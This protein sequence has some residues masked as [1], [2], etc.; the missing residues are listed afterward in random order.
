MAPSWVGDVVMATPAIRALR[1]RFPGARITVLTRQT[2]ADVL[3]HNPHI[4]RTIVADKKGVGP[5]TDNTGELA[6]LLRAG[7]FDLAVLLPNSF[8][9]ALLAWRAQAER[10]VGYAVQWRSMLLTDR[11]SP[12]REDGKIV[13]INMVDRYLALC[14][15][16]GCTE[17]SQDEE[18]FASEQDIAG[19]NEVLA[20]Q[21]I[22]EDDPLAVLIPGASYG[23]SKLWGAEKFAQVADGLVDRHHFK[24]LAHVGPGEEE[25]GQQVADASVRGVTV[26]PP[27]TVDLKLLKGVIR[28]SAVVIANDTGPRHYAVAYGVPNVAVLGPT[29]RRYIDVN[30]EH[31]ELVQAEVD[32]GPCQLKV[33]P[34]DHQCMKL[35]TP[36]QVLEVAESLLDRTYHLPA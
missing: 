17:L 24:V 16:V 23:P 26:P 18:L 35:I 36:G 21:G 9:V 25:I 15:A 7:S 19:A 4:D 27:G 13:P 14:A 30:L 12:P 1:R 5:E 31:T 6:R 32:C 33:C 2:G 8:R 29:S 10:R 34:R 3:E 28:R 22:A 20:S 11:V